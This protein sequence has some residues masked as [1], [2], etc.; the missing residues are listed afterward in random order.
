MKRR[1]GL[2]SDTHGHE[3]AWMKASLLWGN[4]LDAV[5]HAGDVLSSDVDTGLA[6]MIR[7]A[8]FP[9][10]ISRGNCD[11]PEDEKLLHRPILSPYA[12]CMVEREKYPYGA[13]KRFR[14]V[15][16]SCVAK[17]GR[18]CGVR[19]YARASVVREEDPFVNP[20]SAPFRGEGIPPAPH[21]STKT[22]SSSSRLTV[23][24]CTE[25][26]GYTH[27]IFERDSTGRGKKMNPTLATKETQDLKAREV[28]SRG[29]ER[30][31]LVFALYEED[32]G[33]DVTYVREI[34]RVPPFITRVPNSPDYIRG[35]IN[36]RGSI[37][38]VFD[39]ELKIGMMQK[40]LTEEARIVVVS[41]NEILFGIIVDSVREVCTIYDSQIESA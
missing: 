27:D 29:T 22:A 16:E 32:F 38:P 1:L 6:G 5:L 33:L 34:V 30:I 10:I 19:T 13:W 40:E 31:T 39:M 20:G 8:P 26:S 36:L 11:Y 15:P 3:D 37:V 17:Q 7:T 28:E 24:S 18:P 25:N 21:S 14:A 4:S 12:F 2:R 9:V 35:V 41:W 23:R